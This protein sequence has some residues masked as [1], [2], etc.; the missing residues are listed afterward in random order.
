M[1]IVVPTH[2][3][4]S[5]LRDCVESLLTQDFPNDRYEV[6]V[7]DDG[8]VDETPEIVAASRAKISSPRLSYLRPDTRGSNVAR[9]AGI[10]AA[11][12][13]PV[14][15]VDDDI[16]APPSWLKAIAEGCRRHPDAGCLGGPARLR[17]EGKAPRLCQRDSLGETDYEL[18]G[19]ERF[20]GA[21]EA[22]A[23]AN[24]VL[25]KYALMQVG[26]FN[27]SLVGQQGDETEW[28]LRFL[29][30][31]GRMIYLPD[32]WVWHRRT[33]SDLRLW[34]LL[35]KRFRRGTQDV[36]FARIVGRQISLG[37]E[38]SQIPRFLAHAVRR[39]CAAG[40]LSATMRAGRAWGLLRERALMVKGSN[41]NR[42]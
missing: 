24:M 35:R 14:V 33:A 37:N 15:L 27:E 7:V 20:V 30:L 29:K 41:E 34:N 23:G 9:N 21:T 4:A 40:L 8:S 2:N 11:A 25:R 28:L 17:L 12:G 32:A 1:S 22:V 18:G 19:E 26:V 16:E 3:R 6:I 42:G 5:L 10:Q 39:R 13:D 36:G 31:N 38:L